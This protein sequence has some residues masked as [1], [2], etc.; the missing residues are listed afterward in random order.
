MSVT[1]NTIESKT[2]QVM[3]NDLSSEI[4]EI[5]WKFKYK[6]KDFNNNKEAGSGVGVF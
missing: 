6:G 2:S 1:E 4:M 3:I 5:K